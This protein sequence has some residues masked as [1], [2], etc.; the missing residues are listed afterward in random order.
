VYCESFLPLN[1]PSR[2]EKPKG[3]LTGVQARL[4]FEDIGT[5]YG[6]DFQFIYLNSGFG[7]EIRPASATGSRMCAE[8]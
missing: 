1:V 2:L 7:D 6:L 8:A 5:H 3:E 4:Y